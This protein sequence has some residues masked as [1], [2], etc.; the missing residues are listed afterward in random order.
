MNN[1][2]N[3]QESNV[4]QANEI[5]GFLSWFG[6]CPNLPE[7]SGL[8][9]YLNKNQTFLVSGPDGRP[10]QLTPDNYRA[11]LGDRFPVEFYDGEA[12]SP[13]NVQRIWDRAIKDSRPSL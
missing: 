2:P 8:G 12:E 10:V 7:S 9:L 6:P 1:N 5:S 11:V 4:K 13:D 3:N